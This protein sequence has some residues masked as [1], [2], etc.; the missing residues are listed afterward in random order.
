[1]AARG[2][3]GAVL[4]PDQ[5]ELVTETIAKAGRS[6]WARDVPSLRG[7]WK[8]QVKRGV[9]GV[10]NWQAEEHYFG[11]RS[12]D[13]QRR[14]TC[15][16]R[17]TWRAISDSYLN[18][19]LIR[20]QI[21]RPVLPAWEPIYRGS[22]VVVGKNRLGNGDGSVGAWA[23]MWLDLYG[24]VER[25]KYAGVDLSSGNNESWAVQN[26]AIPPAV[27]E[28]GKRVS[29][30]AWRCRDCDDFADAIASGFS[31][32][33]CRDQLFGDRD[34]NGFA[35]EDGRG[36]HCECLR[37]VL[38]LDNGETAF[39]CQQS[40]GDNNPSGP[41]VLQ[42]LEGRKIRLPFGAYG[43]RWETVERALRGGW[44]AWAFQVVPGGELR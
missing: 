21:G 33:W 19:L 37:G 36:A 29:V 32:A 16:G 41:D 30:K 35:R 1:M 22:R 26:G 18:A 4:L 20:G 12:A 2:P 6:P 14:G 3:L 17:G 15:V 28:A 10:F 23:A 43:L 5:T 8:R 31:V 11:R 42:Y 40:W 38:R 13:F 25:L 9:A 44:E 34:A 27:L 7:H 24:F 39:V